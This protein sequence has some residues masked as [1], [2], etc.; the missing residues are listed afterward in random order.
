MEITYK[1]GT[2]PTAQQVIELYDTAGLKRPTNDAGRIARMYQNSN[3]VVS[4][5]HGDKLVGVS[6]ALTDFC[7][8]CYL[9]DLAVT[10][11]Y[12]KEGI[13]K[14]L[15]E[16]TKEAIGDE[17]MLLLL[18]ATTAMEYYPKVGMETVHN[19]FIIH[20]IK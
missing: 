14:K 20:R 3:L 8:S 1:T 4:A 9:S 7:Y 13:G 6:R 2:V 11:D 16:L 18:S 17:T 19:G 10:K 15:I 12:Q 5:W